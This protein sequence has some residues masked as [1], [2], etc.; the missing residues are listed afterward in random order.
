MTTM[1]WKKLQWVKS[2]SELFTF[3]NSLKYFL[4]CL[5]GEI[6]IFLCY[7]ILSYTQKY[8]YRSIRVFKSDAVILFMTKVV[9]CKAVCKVKGV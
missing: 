3:L 9:L 5:T 1:Q 6:Y 8:T 4:L 7:N 2:A